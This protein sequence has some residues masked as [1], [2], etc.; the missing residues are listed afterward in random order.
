MHR[1]LS[2]SFTAA[3]AVTLGT[4][5][6]SAQE[7]MHS[8]AGHGAEHIAN[9]GSVE[10]PNSGA[11]AAKGPFLRGVALLHSFEY[12]EAAEAFRNARAKDSV[13]ALA[14]WMEAL[15]ERQPLWGSENLPAARRALARLAPTSS[16]RLQRAGTPRERGYGAAIEALFADQTEEVRARAF[17]DSMRSLARQFPEDLEAAAF[18]SLALQGALGFTPRAEQRAVR[19]EAASLASRVFRANPTHPG[20]AHYLIHVYDDPALAANGVEAARAYARIAPASEHALHMPSHVFVHLGLWD[21]MASSNEAA[22]AASL[23]KGRARRTSRA[24]PDFHASHWLHYAYMQQGRL[25]EAA[26]LDAAIRQMQVDL[27]PAVTD[28]TYDMEVYY[29]E[30]MRA[31]STATFTNDWRTFPDVHPVV[32]GMD[33]DAVP[34]P[35]DWAGQYALYLNAAAAAHR[36][37][38]E[39]ASRI[40]KSFHTAADTLK[41][42]KPWMAFTSVQLDGISALTRG[43]TAQAITLLAQAAKLQELARASG[44]PLVQ[45]SNELLGATLLAARRPREAADAYQNALTR[46]PNRAEA[47]LGLARARA[48]MGDRDAARVAYR[49]L[50]TNWK[51]ADATLPVL[52]EVRA[53]AMQ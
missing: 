45:S 10:F 52:R 22:W 29:G 18:A 40:A 51:H 21:D 44:P 26:R 36:G 14:C 9:L 35:V 12:P 38:P 33:P 28:S 8:H 37:D 5:L 3:V 11:K 16:E 46:T 1:L 43:D 50:L 32:A 19:E 24:E 13:F 25:R 53:G 48:A 15:T 7:D 23:A 17:G 6:L 39:P 49:Q 31:L 4:T 42:G 30:A 34:P 20:A 27:H 47:L 41:R 2:G